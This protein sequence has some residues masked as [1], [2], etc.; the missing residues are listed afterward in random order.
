M[1]Y[2]S[3]IRKFVD[4]AFFC[5]VEISPSGDQILYTYKEADDRYDKYI[6]TLGAYYINEKTVETLEK[7][8]GGFNPKWSAEGSLFSLL[9]DNRL[10]IYESKSR[11][12]ID[13]IKSVRM[14]NDYAWGADGKSLWILTRSDSPSS[15]TR[16]LEAG[17][18]NM[19]SYISHV[20]LSNGETTDLIFE[21]SGVISNFIVGKDKL[22]YALKDNDVYDFAGIIKE[23]DLKDHRIRKISTSA[24][25]TVISF[26][27]FGEQEELILL[28]YNQYPSN[29]CMEKK[30]YALDPKDGAV[31]LFLEP[32]MER[33]TCIEVKSTC[34]KVIVKENDGMRS[35]LYS[36]GDSS[37]PQ[38]SVEKCITNI[39]VG[40]NG[41][42]AFV[43]QD[44]N[45]HPML[46]CCMPDQ[47]H[48]VSKYEKVPLFDSPKLKLNA[49]VVR[50]EAPDEKQVEGILIPPG[51]E[52]SGKRPLIV[53][54]TGRS[55][56]F[57]RAYLGGS[58]LLGGNDKFPYPV[59][60]FSEMG[61]YT[62]LANCRSTGYHE[63]EKLSN[64]E[65]SSLDGYCVNVMKGIQSVLE[66]NQDIDPDRIA[67][68][69]W[70]LG[71][72]VAARI[73]CWPDHPV[74]VCVVGNAVTDLVS[75]FSCSNCFE[76]MAFMRGGFWK[77]RS[78]L[79][80]YLEA[81]PISH[82]DHMKAATYIQHGVLDP[83][84]P[85]EQGREFYYA[86][87]LAGKKVSMTEFTHAGHTFDNP[88]D[89]S[90]ASRMVVNWIRENL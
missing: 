81:S 77:S 3:S 69:G 4:T 19:P 18:F 60:Q 54:T 33:G 12:I 78:Q 30:L 39:S 66:E 10:V 55:N 73:A 85:V 32:R 28:G 15:E 64:T 41:R 72:Y 70:S 58:D 7:G 90:D 44:F 9:K 29:S 86:L 43:M 87:R 22:Y 79:L 51:E 65:E 74:K 20:N 34:R 67:V 82:I 89:L 37:Y 59:A 52:H 26:V 6:E 21:E 80:R 35:A 14:I 63:F 38:V 16:L 45:D 57:T 17:Q 13:E 2:S 36:A 46:C 8:S 31:S 71:G 5:N 50:W 49:A 68:M 48:D 88:G 56:S 40:E 23:M 1:N 25:L 27:G 42:I 61:C 11:K 76:F 83:S 75:M 53:I 84:I 24:D 62:L 47:L